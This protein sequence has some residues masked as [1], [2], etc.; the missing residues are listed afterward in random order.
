MSNL[1][2]KCFRTEQERPL[3]GKQGGRRQCGCWYHD[4]EGSFHR[5]EE[6][7]SR[8]CRCLEDEVGQT[9]ALCSGSLV[10][11]A[12]DFVSTVELNEKALCALENKGTK[13]RRL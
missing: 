7:K 10:A 8:L 6:M 13:G 3:G 1:I 11:K 4:G 9:E 5:A 2:E 12:R